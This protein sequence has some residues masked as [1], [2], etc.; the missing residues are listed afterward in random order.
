VTDPNLSLIVVI[1]DRSGSMRSIA[2]AT[3]ENVNG[4]IADQKAAPGEALFHMVQFSDD[5]QTTCDFA[6]IKGVSPLSMQDYRPSGSTALLDAMGFTITEIGRRLAAMPEEKRPG[7]VVVAVV[8]DGEE[9]VSREYG[10]YD[11][12]QRVFDMVRHQT[13]VYSWQ[14]LFLGANQDAIAVGTS[15]GFAPAN[16]MTYTASAA[17]MDVMFRSVSKNVM[18]YRE[19]G[20]AASLSFTDEQRADNADPVIP[21]GGVT[22][23]GQGAVDPLDVLKIAV[24]NAKNNG[25]P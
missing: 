4:F 19:C 20:D 6:P 23:I 8:T 25:T 11:G 17:G 2:D 16:S 1:L 14:F 3:R 12:R 22:I 13:D 10:G 24:D 7:R 15:F 18:S 5:V 21:A 9:N